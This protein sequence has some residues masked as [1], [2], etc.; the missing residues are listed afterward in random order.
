MNNDTRH[1][2]AK[3]IRERLL[4]K[5]YLKDSDNGLNF[6]YTDYK[7]FEKHDVT[8]LSIKD[9]NFTRTI[10]EIK[11]RNIE[12]K[13]TQGGFFIQKDKYDYLMAQGEKYDR[14]EYINIFPDGIIVWDLKK[15]NTPT[16][17]KEILPVN[18]HSNSSKEKEVGFLFFWEADIVINKEI[19]IISTLKKAYEIIDR[20]EK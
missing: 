11:V 20:I 10:S 5:Q 4:F 13:K 9:L 15:L 1:Y 19:N 14:I 7:S 12:Y 2:R 17:H 8:F 6:K 3:S 16:F 18:N